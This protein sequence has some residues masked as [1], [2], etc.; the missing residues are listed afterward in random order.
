MSHLRRKRKP[1]CS[2][3]G[4][5]PAAC[6]CE[7]LPCLRFRTPIAIVQ[8]VRERFKP[9]NTGRLLARMVE[10][11]PLLP[12]GMREP[13]FDPG[14]LRDPSIEWQLLYPREGAP[15][16]EVRP[17]RRLGFVLLDGSWHQCSH[18]SRRLPVVSE[19]PCVALPPGPPAMWTVRAQHDERGRSTFEAGL[20]VLEL[21]EGAEAVAPLRR[22]FAEI[23]ARML[24]LKGRI[25][26][27]NSE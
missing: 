18:M 14:P 11:T 27:E 1:R 15:P 21:M 17:G 4:L 8:H 24:H 9:T 3:C 5:P 10:S 16:L 12:V 25:A 2:G 23:T 20:R 19:L 7:L 26:K 22:A 6:C 13:A